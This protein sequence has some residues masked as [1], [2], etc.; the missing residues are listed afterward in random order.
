LAADA[1]N[2]F[3]SSSLNDPRTWKLRNTFCLPLINRGGKGF[4]HTFFRQIE[5]SAYHSN[6]NGDNSAP[7]GAINFLDCGCGAWGGLG[8]HGFI[9][10]IF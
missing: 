9:V 1:I 7:L 3:M 4:L 10:I 8:G 2:G 6:E 5:V